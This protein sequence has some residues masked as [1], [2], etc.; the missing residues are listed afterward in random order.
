MYSAVNRELIPTAR[1]DCSLVGGWYHA[2]AEWRLVADALAGRGPV[3]ERMLR[4]PRPSLLSPVGECGG[5]RALPL[6]LVFRSLSTSRYAGRRAGTL[7]LAEWLRVRCGV[8]VGVG[9]FTFRQFG[10]W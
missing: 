2:V 1:R 4:P 3:R 7:Y 9:R 6:V 5:D 10:R 8:L